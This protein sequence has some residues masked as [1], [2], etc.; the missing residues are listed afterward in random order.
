MEREKSENCSLTISVWKA[1]FSHTVL[2]IFQLNLLEFKVNV[3]FT[4][5]A[6]CFVLALES[7]HSLCSPGS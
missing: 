2:D 4:P 3:G 1:L 5:A 6:L 7:E